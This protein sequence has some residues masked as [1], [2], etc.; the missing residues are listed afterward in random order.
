MTEET[1][2]EVTGDVQ[3]F[4]AEVRNVHRHGLQEKQPK[5]ASLEQQQEAHDYK[6]ATEREELKSEIKREVISELEESGR[7]APLDS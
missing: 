5:S 4:P 1:K 2:E 6:K 3:K 7:L